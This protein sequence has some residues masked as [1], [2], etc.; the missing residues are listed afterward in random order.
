[1]QLKTHLKIDQNLS[2][3]PVELREGYAVVVLET[4]ENMVADEK[5]L[6][7][8]GFIF[9]LADYCAMLAVNEPTVVLASAKVDFRKPVVLG[10]VLKAEG[11]VVK[12]EGKKRW[13]EVKVFRNLD[14]VFEGEFLCVI[15]EKHVLSLFENP[16]S[17]RT[18]HP[19]ERPLNQ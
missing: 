7:H 10:D 3:K 19:A 14:L 18:P 1:M 4:K 13:V 11:K 17:G 5:G 8:G 15:P 2:G 9:S 16:S 12:S 6:I